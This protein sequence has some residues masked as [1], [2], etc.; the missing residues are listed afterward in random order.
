M[1]FHLFVFPPKDLDHLPEQLEIFEL[2]I[3]RVSILHILL[4]S[5][6]CTHFPD[7]PYFVYPPAD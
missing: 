7:V 5:S 1:H 6:L 4:V 3:P 2:V